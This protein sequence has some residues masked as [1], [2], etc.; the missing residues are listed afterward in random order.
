VHRQGGFTLVEMMVAVAILGI[1][2]GVLVLSFNKPARKVRSGSEVSGMFAELHRAQSSYALEHGRY[3][4]TGTGEDDLF[5][6]TPGS[7][8]QDVSD[9]PE[10]WRTLRA[11][12]IAGKLHCG[13]VTV[14][15]TADDDL[16]DFALDFDMEQPAGNW[17]AIYARCNADGDTAV[18]ATYFTS[19]VDTTIVRRNEGR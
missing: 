16:P 4:S 2:A 1:L 5:P 7:Q 8:A 9:L 12:P 19:S 3:Y 17:Y 6:T 14:A 15:G 11:Q 18:D 13:Y 10:A